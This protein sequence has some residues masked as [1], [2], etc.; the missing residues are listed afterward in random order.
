MAKN[1]RCLTEYPI[2]LICDDTIGEIHGY[3]H[4]TG[5]TTA[6][7]VRI[8][9]RTLL[10]AAGLRPERELIFGLGEPDWLHICGNCNMVHP[11]VEAVVNEGKQAGIA[12]YKNIRGSL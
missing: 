12:A 5:C 9:C 7:G 11:M 10:I 6:K 2:R 4:L 3:P 1:Q 8:P